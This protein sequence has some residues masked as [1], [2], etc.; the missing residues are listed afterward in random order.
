VAQE[1]GDSLLERFPQ[2]D[3]V[4]GPDAYHRLP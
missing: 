4:V 2:I 3:L 1:H